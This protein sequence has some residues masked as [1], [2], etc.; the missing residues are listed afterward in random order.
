VVSKTVP[1]SVASGLDVFTGG[2]P[3]SDGVVGGVPVHPAATIATN[4]Q[5]I[6]R[7]ASP[8]CLAYVIARSDCDDIAVINTLDGGDC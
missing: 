1:C 4:I 7:M 6:M 2:V 3:D 8:P 5:A